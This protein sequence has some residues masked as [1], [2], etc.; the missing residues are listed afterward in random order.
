MD[1]YEE[2]QFMPSRPWEATLRPLLTMSLAF[3]LGLTPGIA[4]AAEQA[5]P[6]PAK[7][8]ILIVEGDG[9]INNVRQRTAREP[10]IQVEDENHRPVAGAA[11]LFMLPDSGPSGVFT[12][13]GRTLATKTDSAGRAV[14]K[15]LQVN[16]VK[17]KF[18]IQVQATYQGVTAS[19]TIAQVNAVLSAGAGGGG[20][21]GKMIAILAAAGGA[22]AVGVVLATRGGSNTPPSNPTTVSAGTPTV[23]GP[24]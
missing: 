13:G 12:G 4:P 18:Q 17:G 11:I 16:K 2:E 6:A 8:N 3:L 19:A 1:T 7:L 22:V 23:G 24:Q 15:G 5:Q 14:A 20:I 9:A 21:S 10:I